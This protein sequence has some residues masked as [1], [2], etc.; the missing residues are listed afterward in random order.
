MITVTESRLRKIIRKALKEQAESSPPPGLED[1]SPAYQRG[2]QDALDGAPKD[3][4]ATDEYDVGYEDGSHD[5]DLSGDFGPPV[6]GYKTPK[7]R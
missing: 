6:S 7:Y 1:D 5:A 2:Y 3:N 4:E